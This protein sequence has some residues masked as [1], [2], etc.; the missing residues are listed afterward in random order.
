[1][2]NVTIDS[3]SVGIDFSGFDLGDLYLATDTISSSTR[4]KLSF[5]DGS[6]FEFRGSEF[7]F[8]GDGE[9]SAGTVTQI[10]THEDDV[11]V[12]MT[13]ID[14]PATDITDAA[15]TFSTKDDKKILGQAFEGDDTFDGGGGDD[16]VRGY[17]GDD[18]L[19][20]G[21]G[22]DSLFGGNDDDVILGAKGKDR[23]YGGEGDDTLA[24]GAGKDYLSGKD[25]Q[26]TFRFNAYVKSANADKIADFVHGEDMIQLDND[27]F[28]EIGDVG[29]LARKAFY[30]GV[31]AHDAS[32]RIVY[33]ASAGKLFYDEDGAGS[34]DKVLFA[35]VGAGTEITYNDFYV[36]G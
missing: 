2:A 22:A 16:R 35:S 32:D 24:G 27:F 29:Q 1:M 8:N 33:D 23:L 17:K 6:Y 15:R 14:V 18:T 9:F 10:R 30:L 13:D 36:I 11:T 31:D 20:G 25:G 21:S 3:D 4:Y 34:A 28:E 5:D 19:R 7:E 26:D 12:T